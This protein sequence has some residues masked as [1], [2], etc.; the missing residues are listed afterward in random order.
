MLG[1]FYV[2][3]IGG[4]YLRG[5]GFFIGPR[6]E[7]ALHFKTKTAA[8]NSGRRAR[9]RALLPGKFMILRVRIEEVKP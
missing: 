5:D 3:K 2:V 8:K 9:D 4:C 7:H 6:L 1:E